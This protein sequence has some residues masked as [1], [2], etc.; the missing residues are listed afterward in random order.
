MEDPIFSSGHEACRFAYAF[1][2]QQYALTA[3]AK[4]M[5][6]GVI[7]SGRGLV[8]LD[9]AAI[10]G[11]VK[12][13]VEAM[14]YPYAQ[15]IAARYELDKPK[16]IEAMLSLR[17]CV[18]AGL[19]TGVHRRVVVDA[20]TMRYFGQR[21]ENNQPVKLA[22]LCS[23]TGDS[24]ATMSRRWGLVKHHLSAVERKADIRIDESLVESG[25]VTISC[26]A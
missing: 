9:G 4:M 22:S 25:I 21:D 19:G 15:V 11:T 17:N 3:M 23:A 26:A 24:T 6:G 1:S 2:S 5:R 12:R 14:G 10:A 8:G 18:M 16:K 7:G 20:L 13:H